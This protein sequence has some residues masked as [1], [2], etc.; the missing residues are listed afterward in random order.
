M[1]KTL[2]LPSIFVFRVISASRKRTGLSIRDRL[3]V[4]NRS[5]LLHAAWKIEIEKDPFLSVV[6]KSK[7]FPNTSPWLSSNTTTKSI[8]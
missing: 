8:F 7:Y 6:L 5:L 3:L 1:R 2:L 4:V